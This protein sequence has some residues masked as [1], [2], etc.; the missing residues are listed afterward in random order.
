[1]PVDALKKESFWLKFEFQ[2]FDAGR[3][4]PEV[5]KWPGKKAE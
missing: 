5:S 3:A 2:D 1:V 4:F